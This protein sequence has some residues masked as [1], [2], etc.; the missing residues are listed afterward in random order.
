MIL[1]NFIFPEWINFLSNCQ[2]IIKAVKNPARLPNVAE[3]SKGINEIVPVP[4]SE[5]PITTIKSL[6]EGGKRFSIY[7]KKNIKVNP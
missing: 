1:I 3:K 5:P 2:P 7:A 6:G 4:T